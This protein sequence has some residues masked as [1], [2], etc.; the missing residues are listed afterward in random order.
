MLLALLIIFIALP[1]LEISLMIH[2]G[3]VLGTWNTVALII[4]SAVIGASLVR[5]QGVAKL[6]LVREK[7]AKGELPGIE[8]V[9]SMMLAIAGVFLVLP[10]FITDFIGLLF[11]TPFTRK[12]IA[13]Y[14]FS[15]MKV[16]IVSNQSF[17]QPNNPFGSSPFDHHSND[18]HGNTFEGDFER[19]PEEVKPENR[20]NDDEK[21]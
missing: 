9:E 2:V 10:G 5:S 8:I 4:L 15:R 13:Q 11:I 17:G 20:L 7:M 3:Q 1:V 14:I 18:Q 21:K 16:N 12:P 19:K 6:I